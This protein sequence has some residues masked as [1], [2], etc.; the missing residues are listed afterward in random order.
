MGPR[1]HLA[2]QDEEDM[3]QGSS[4]E[5][6]ESDQDLSETA[7]EQ[8]PSLIDVMGRTVKVHLNSNRKP[9]RGLKDNQ[10]NKVTKS[11]SI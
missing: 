5:D 2:I 9:T 3:F 10:G 11:R 4:S 1:K 8:Q 7:K 6:N